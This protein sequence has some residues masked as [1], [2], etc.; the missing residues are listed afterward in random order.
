MAASGYRKISQKR[1]FFYSAVIVLVTHGLVILFFANLQH[2]KS[3]SLNTSLKMLQLKSAVVE[4][5]LVIEMPV[6][7]FQPHL[8]HPAVPVIEFDRADD[9]SIELIHSSP[10][11]AQELPIKTNTLYRNA[12]DPKLQQK[13]IDAQRFNT[14]RRAEKPISRTEADGRIF[15]DMGNGNCLVSM[16]KADSRDRGTNWGHARCGKTDSEEM[17]DRVNADLEARRNPLNR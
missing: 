9:A 4:S 5:I 1:N 2:S 7:N 6:I 10:D 17:M 13:L 3:S 15:V 8:N 14:A 16:P 11:L 12:F